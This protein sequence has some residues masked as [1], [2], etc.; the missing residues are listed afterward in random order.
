MWAYATASCRD[1]SLLRAATRQA[2]VLARSHAFTS[3]KQPLS[4]LW[5]FR[6]FG[7]SVHEAN[8]LLFQEVDRLKVLEVAAAGV[9]GQAV[10]AQKS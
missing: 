10:A 7:V 2:I 6:A 1:R 3:S 9:E 4:L 5:S 8:E